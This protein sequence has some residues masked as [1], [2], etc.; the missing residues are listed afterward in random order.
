[1]CK[2]RC[3]KQ[4]TENKV[5]LPSTA[6]PLNYAIHL[7]PDLVNFTFA[8]SEKIDYEVTGETNE[9][10]L[11]ARDLMILPSSVSYESESK[12]LAVSTVAFERS[13]VT[14]TFVDKLPQGKGSLSV[15]FSGTLNDQMAGF[16]RSGYTDAEG[17]SRFMATTQ[18]EAIDARRMFPCVDEPAA[19]A[20][21][22]LTVTAPADLTVLS[23]MPEAEKV[24]LKGSENQ[25]LQKVR[26]LPTPIM[27]TYLLALC[28]G[29]FEF[30]QTTT[31]RG[32][33]V[34]VLST[35]GKSKECEFALSVGV[36]SL[37]F[38]EDFFA[39]PYPLPKM[40]MIGVPDFAMGAMENWGLITYREIDLLCDSAT[41]SVARKTRL[42]SVIAHEIA[43]Q[44]FGNLVTMSWWDDL[45]L[46]E[47][48]ATF[49]QSYC[50]DHLFPEWGIWDQYVAEDLERA[51]ALDG[52]RS[53]HPIQVPIP[54][55]EDVEQVFDAISYCKGAAVV[56]TAFSVLG[57]A[58]FKSGLRNY[59]KKHAY[60]NTE[61]ED[62]W[63]SLQN[64]YDESNKQ[65]DKINISQI[66]GTWTEQMGYPVISVEQSNGKFKVNQEWFLS[67]GS[68]ID[69][70]SQKLWK[71]PIFIGEKLVKIIA[72]KSESI[73]VVGTPKLNSGELAMIRVDYASSIQSEILKNISNQPVCDRL[74]ILS[75]AR[76]FARSGRRSLTDLI[77]TL[78]AFSGER[79]VDVWSS[80]EAAIG[81]IDR[82]VRG[83][84]RDLEICKFVIRL[85]GKHLQLLGWDSKSGESDAEK[86]CRS[87]ILRL[88]GSYCSTDD[89]ELVAEARRRFSAYKLDQNT[90]L[91][92]DDTRTAVLRMVL[93]NPIDDLSNENDWKWLKQ[94]AEKSE[95]SQTAKLNIYAAI[96]FVKSPSLKRATL[97]WSMSD[98][99][100]L[101]D[102]FYPMMSVRGSDVAGA[103]LAWDWLLLRWTDL[104]NKLAKASPSLLSSVVH[105]LGAGA[106]SVKRAE[107][108]YLHFGKEA[109]LTRTVANLTEAT[110]TA[111]A[112]L[113][114]SKGTDAAK[115]SFWNT[116]IS[117]I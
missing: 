10:K 44:W 57:E 14:F 47:G 66:M 114:R 93:A 91:L 85:A 34:R 32:T 84:G 61:T 94:I 36:R 56:R 35:P 5:L 13:V 80:I 75:D 102:F 4:T 31:T 65:S 62:L 87:V 108:I 69:A 68:N 116:L 101:Q 22:E 104:K 88:V 19:K 25:L 109:V 6:R 45:W 49:M 30:L 106:V 111:A 2:D 113:E 115:E 42:A 70:D 73:D 83:L 12:R 53:S 92:S 26:F 41:V 17:K 11:H 78:S 67:D 63:E 51:K 90:H 103:D 60:G 1:M 107:E 95:T 15:H 55:A 50:C 99:I 21:F 117:K 48:F 18:L 39:Q 97:E 112:F 58:V 27:S 37:S 76:A 100:K 82:V 81:G 28:V 105:A 46:N 54:H 3:R 59:M 43:H 86:R 98:K 9:I 20:I 33:L 23:N 8:G 40:D 71:V 52:L 77:S 38:Y 74:G 79:N 24:Y 7:T 16:Y 89:S 29:Q 64:A 72:E 96:G 110:R